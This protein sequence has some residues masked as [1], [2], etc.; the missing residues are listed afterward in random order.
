[1]A[2]LHWHPKNRVPHVTI[3][4]LA[5]SIG[6]GISFL[7]ELFWLINSAFALAIFPR[8]SPSIAFAFI[9]LFLGQYFLRR[10]ETQYAAY[11]IILG[12]IVGTF[13]SII[14]GA[15]GINLYVNQ[16]FLV[17]GFAQAP[18]FFSLS[19]AFLLIVI[20][21]ALLFPSTHILS[22]EKWSQLFLLTALIVAGM[23]MLGY[24]YDAEVF[25]SSPVGTPMSFTTSVLALL[26][27]IAA[28]YA[29]RDDG[30]LKIITN[31]TSSAIMMRRVLPLLIVMPHICALIVL[32]S[33]RTLPVSLEAAAAMVIVVGE[34]FVIAIFWWNAQKLDRSEIEHKAYARNLAESEARYRVLF[35]QSTDIILISDERGRYIDANPQAEKLIG[36]SRD[37]LLHLAVGDLSSHEDRSLALESFELC[38][39]DGRMFGEAVILHKNGRHI[40]IEYAS[41]RIAPGMYQSVLHDITAYKQVEG[42]LRYALEK[43]QELNEMKSRFV[44]MVSHEFRTPL[45]IIRTSS[46]ILDRYNHK[47]TDGQRKEYFTNVQ[48]QVTHMV[49]LLEDVLTISKSS[50]VGVEFAPE[51]TELNAMCRQIID[52]FQMTTSTHMI[53]YKST[54]EVIAANIDRK[55]FRQALTNLLSNALKY[56]PEKDRIIVDLDCKSGTVCLRVQDFGIG[57]PVEDQGR[58]FE[59]FHRARNV[60]DIFGTGLGLAIVK[61]AV[62]AHGGAINF[63]SAEGTTFTVT[64]PQPAPT[65]AEIQSGPEMIPTDLI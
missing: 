32:K 57:I 11:I 43:E 47:L 26:A 51:Y 6:L 8:T 3:S 35:E 14:E 17:T 37:E 52:E 46:D 62:E 19:T 54:Q 18:T 53:I 28:L 60:G 2:V 7:V 42:N 15:F 34:V 4:S 9:L 33:F 22:R 65:I 50:T 12:V 29:S 56:S 5:I 1:M 36:Y 20:S 41:T 31:P 64:L 55:L 61:Q 49:Q 27:V 16:L 45:S 24:L 21:A 10:K 39:L 13:L 40:V 58:L 63:S 59:H 30:L 38:K 23:A 25:Y 44:S 48:T